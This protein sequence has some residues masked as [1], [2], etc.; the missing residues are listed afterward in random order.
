VKGRKGREGKKSCWKR[1]RGDGTKGDP[2]LP[3]PDKEAGGSGL[4]ARH[5][6]YQDYFQGEL[7][8]TRW[9]PAGCAM[10]G[11]PAAHLMGY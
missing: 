8:D 10:E 11:A 6:S 7:G 9:P 1:R 3:L 5:S 2:K 4:L